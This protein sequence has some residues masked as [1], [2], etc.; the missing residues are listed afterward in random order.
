MNYEYTLHL[1]EHPNGSES[2]EHSL[3]EYYATE[4]QAIARAMT[5][6]DE[7]RN[8]TRS[9]MGGIIILERWQ[10]E[11]GEEYYDS[12][13]YKYFEVSDNRL[14]LWQERL[15]QAQEAFSAVDGYFEVWDERQ[16]KLWYVRLKDHTHNVHNW[17]RFNSI[18]EG[19]GRLDIVVA[20]Q[21]HDATENVFWASSYYVQTERIDPFTVQNI[22]QAVKEIL[23]KVTGCNYEDL[24]I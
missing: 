17:S 1:Y 22:E 19:D 15:A 16:E 2:T 11:D 10:I 12:D 23:E 20:P 24:T 7:Y 5:L 4:E 8:N 3:K 21:G 14:L 9:L 13:Y 18:K 6:R